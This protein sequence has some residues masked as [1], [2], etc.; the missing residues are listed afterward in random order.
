GAFVGGMTRAAFFMPLRDEGD[1]GRDRNVTAGPVPGPERLQ[2]APAPW[3]DWHD[4]RP[5]GGVEFLTSPAGPGRLG[6]PTRRPA[7]AAGRPD[8]P[9]A[10][11]P[12]ARGGV[13]D[14]PLRVAR[15]RQGRAGAGAEAV[16]ALAGPG[17]AAPGRVAAAGGAFGRDAGA[18]PAGAGGAPPPR[19]AL[20]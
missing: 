3:A 16:A 4:L 7:H 1:P 5:G 6:G 10:G 11:R 8:G 13:L 19:A 18:R 14:G 9:R 20:R 15:Q 17:G 2:A 12:G